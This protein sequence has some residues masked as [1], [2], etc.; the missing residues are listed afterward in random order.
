MQSYSE[1]PHSFN[2]PINYIE[3]KEQGKLDTRKIL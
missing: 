1:A 3:V 2:I